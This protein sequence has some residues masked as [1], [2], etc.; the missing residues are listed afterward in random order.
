[1]SNVFVSREQTTVA[2]APLKRGLIVSCQ[3]PD[4][5]PIDT[6]EFIS[7]QAKTVLQAG[8]IGIR[9][10]GVANVKAVAAAVSVPIIGLIKRY[11]ESSLIH[12]T[13]EIED[14]LELEKVGADIVAIDATGRL[15][16]NAVS[17]PAFMEE[18]RRRT[19]VAILADVDTVEAAIQAEAL[20]CDAIATTLSGYTE[21]PAP[22]LPNI[23]LI[24][25]IT[26]R[27]KIPVIAEGGFSKPEHVMQ[28]FQAG[29]WSV[30]IG[31]A[32][33]N[34]YLLTKSFVQVI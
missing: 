24:S 26:Q 33:T 18:L 11:S 3:V 32:I 31:T 6:P 22:K 2:F 5:T 4:G 28:A 10:Q 8:A 29:A 1:M 14:V 34:P 17:F 21:A 19:D 23:K 30:C 27:V 20:G 9:A 15:R 16:E 7:A 25:D 13:P 12:I